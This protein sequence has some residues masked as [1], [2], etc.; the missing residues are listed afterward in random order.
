MS[1]SKDLNGFMDTTWLQSHPLTEKTVLDYFS[2][3]PF[4]DRSCNNEILRMQR[5]YRGDLGPDAITPIDDAWMNEQLALMTGIEYIVHHSTP[6][7]L[8]II[9]MRHRVSKEKTTLITSTTS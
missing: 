5:M 8:F 2:L 4:Y 6:P 3:S 7:S 9:Y 1:S